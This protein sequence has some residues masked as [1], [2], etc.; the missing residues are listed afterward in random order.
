MRQTCLAGNV[1]NSW[2]LFVKVPSTVLVPRVGTRDWGTCPSAS[3]DQPRDPTFSIS[4]TFVEPSLAWN[5]N[6]L[7]FSDISDYRPIARIQSLRIYLNCLPNNS[8][9]APHSRTAYRT[10]KTHLSAQPFVSV[11][12]GAPPLPSR[13]PFV[14][15][16]A[17]S[18]QPIII[19]QC[20]ITWLPLFGLSQQEPMAIDK[21][22][23]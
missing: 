23:S 3:F 7:A 18:I 11:A 1:E 2:G 9:S 12:G 14:E 19:R 10:M 4:C 17:R 5:W 15:F 16:G 22:V 8:L 21:T 13:A 6:W 20:S